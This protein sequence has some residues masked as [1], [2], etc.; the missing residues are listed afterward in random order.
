MTEMIIK[1]MVNHRTQQEADNQMLPDAVTKY[2]SQF[3]NIT[4]DNKDYLKMQ[5]W[6]IKKSPQVELAVFDPKI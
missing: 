4:S 2:R 5:F 3:R 6:M 1:F